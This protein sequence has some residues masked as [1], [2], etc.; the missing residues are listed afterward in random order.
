[1]ASTRISAVVRS[2]LVAAKNSAIALA[3]GPVTSSAARWEPTVSMTAI[4]S[5]A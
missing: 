2:A 4:S 3:W 5:S 1:V